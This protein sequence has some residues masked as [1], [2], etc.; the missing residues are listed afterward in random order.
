M[1]GS[2]NHQQEEALLQQLRNSGDST[3][4]AALEKLYH[5]RQMALLAADVYDAARGVGHAPPGWIRVSEHPE[6]VRQ[7]A[8][9]LHMTDKQLL[10]Q[11][12]PETSGF[13]AEIYLPDPKVL[14][15]GYKPV[16]TFKGSS[17]EVMTSDGL[18]DTTKEDF[19]A[20]NFPQSVGLETDYYDRAMTL[21]VRLKESGLDFELTGHSLSGG[22]ASA[23]AA[24][25]GNHA[26]TLNAAGLH[27][28][29]ARRFGEQNGIPVY[30]LEQ[31]KPLVTSYQVQ[32]ELL[33]NGVQ[34]NIHRMDVIQRAELGGVL[35]ETS[36]L[37]NALPQGRSILKH[38]LDG[39]VPPQAQASV[40]AFVDKLA[41]GNTDKMLRELPLAA[42]EVQ[43][44]LAPM[45]RLNPND[46]ASPLLARNHVLSLP[47]VTCLAGPVLETMSMVA[48]G[49]HVGER[50]GEVVAAGGH[51]T[52]QVLHAAGDGVRGVTE[53]G[54]QAS[55]AVTQFEGA[56]AQ[57]AEHHVGAAVA[58]AREA[59]AEMQ[60]RVDQGLG[61]ARK[62]GASLDA[63][64]LH[65]IGHVLPEGARTWMDAKAA[66]LEHMG[67]EA[68]RLGQA[69]AAEARREGHVDAAAIRAATH[70][71]QSGTGHA[72]TQIGNFQHDAI[73]S[74]GHLAGTGLDASGQ[75]VEGTSRHAPT[76]G[77]AAGAW[78]GADAA[79]A[80]EL[81]PGNYP[82]LYG[83]AVSL[84]QGKE[85]G[86]EAVE[87]HLMRATVL[88]SMDSRIEHVEQLARERLQHAQVPS[89]RDQSAASP[90]LDDPAHPGYA[91]FHQIRDGVYRLDAQMGRPPD[92]QS[93]NL[94]GALT[95]AAKA[96]G[97]SRIDAVA[98]SD[99]GSRAFA[100]QHVVPAALTMNAQVET[101]QAIK[102]SLEQ[103]SMEWQKADRHQAHAQTQ[104]QIRNAPR[105]PTEVE[106]Q[107][108]SMMTLGS[109]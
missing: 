35:K 91:M 79:V 103:S 74:A 78:L 96:G 30:D 89:A 17:G 19:L 52:Q 26:T 47:E 33:S 1:S 39:G 102:T 59:A 94:A 12:H 66:Q 63:G 15:H 73:A 21:A 54:G 60:A 108:A 77:A 62:L 58:H 81:N 50:G 27:P 36:Q 88:P 13:R 107:A 99:D 69:Q 90:R 65:G 5:D 11:L 20:N 55:R 67:D 9:Q 23:A 48:M 10:D 56:V 98:L 25:T 24:V 31:L 85:A 18:R 40:H 42:G 34:D 53:M 29:T 37:L 32:G 2:G 8:L 105:Q 49:A 41:T 84:A 86:A 104:Q 106:Q 76:V 28:E 38:Q 3:D 64:L 4:A 61:Q 72:V 95:A 93:E 14:G 100:L 7:Y 75:F 82:R 71:V 83:A 70:A 109:R 68:S 87:R 6:L 44:L 22:M 43:P 80:M 101:V 57:A 51:A 92:Q 16:V 97:L 46:P 45:T